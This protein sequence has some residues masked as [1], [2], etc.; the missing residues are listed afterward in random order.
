MKVSFDLDDTIFVSP[1]KFKTEKELKFPLNKI[2]KDRLRYGTISLFNYIKRQKI[3]LWI[4]TTSF[5]S[6]K[7]IRN[8]FRCYGLKI[9]AVVNGYRHAEEVQGNKTEPMPSKCPSKYRIDLHIDDD[10]SV[11]QNGKIYG[12]EVFIIG[13]QDNEWD[14]KIIQKIEKIKLY[15]DENQ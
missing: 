11:E 7:Y 14:K 5:R 9:D 3:E 13:Q 15:K 12:F 1:E 2:F 8:L 4:Y 6:E 10:I